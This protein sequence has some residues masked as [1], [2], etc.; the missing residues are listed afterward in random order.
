MVMQDMRGWNGRTWMAGEYH[1][2]GGHDH[3]G[4]DPI[5]LNVGAELDRVKS[6]HDNQ[7]GTADDWKL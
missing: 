7:W 2:N 5:P 3:G 6:R 4:G 1:E